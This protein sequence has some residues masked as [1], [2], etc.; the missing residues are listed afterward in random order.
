M[1][2]RAKAPGSAVTF[3]EVLGAVVVRRRVD[4]KKSQG[5][6]AKDLK[7]SQAALSRLERGRS[8]MSVPHLRTAARTLGVQVSLLV[9]EAE[10]GAE[11]LSHRGISVLDAEPV[12]EE[13]ARWVRVAQ[14]EVE[15]AVA[16]VAIHIKMP[17]ASS[18]AWTWTK[19][20]EKEPELVQVHQ[21]RA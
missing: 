15:A 21:G 17:T 11:A 19:V 7:L 5:E 1:A 12:E 10:L 18:S 2:G 14:K 20:K 3:G 8:T 16:S 4:L 13:K 6:M 9:A